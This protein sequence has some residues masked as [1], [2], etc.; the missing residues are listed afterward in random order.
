MS[1][2]KEPSARAREETTAGNY[3]VS[4]YPPYSFWTKEHVHDLTERLRAHP[5]VDAERVVSLSHVT[6]TRSEDDCLYVGTLYSPGESFDAAA[7]RASGSS[8]GKRR[9]L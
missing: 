1:Q 4:N 5:L 2:S 7:V 9:M 8:G 3:F 6:Y